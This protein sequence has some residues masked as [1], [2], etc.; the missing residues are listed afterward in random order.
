MS[1]AVSR[2]VAAFL[3]SYTPAVRALALGA[4][5]LARAAAPGTTEQV[6]VGGK[7][8]GYGVANTYK[9]TVCV[10]MPL[11]AGV[12]FGFPRGVELADP[13]GLLTGTGKK[14]RHVRLSAPAD[15]KE[16]ALRSLVA[17]SLA[18]AIAATR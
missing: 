4:C 12:N 10:V 1:K 15:L 11:K 16:P 18:L 14:A 9:G 2:D 7:L 5:A 6:D 13:K 8:I 3:A 17:Q